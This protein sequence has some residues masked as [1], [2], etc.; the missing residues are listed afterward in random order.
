MKLFYANQFAL[1]SLSVYFSSALITWRYVRRYLPPCIL[2][3]SRCTPAAAVVIARV[4]YNKNAEKKA[5]RCS[6]LY[7]ATLRWLLFNKD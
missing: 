4:D 5:S 1:S 7:S 3:R 6:N 2:R